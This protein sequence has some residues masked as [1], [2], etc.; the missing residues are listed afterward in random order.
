MAPLQYRLEKR[1]IAAVQDSHRHR[2]LVIDFAVLLECLL[3]T[4]L[5]HV[6]VAAAAVGY[7]VARGD[8]RGITVDGGD[9]SSEITQ[10]CVLIS[11]LIVCQSVAL[12]HADN[13]L[14]QRR[15]F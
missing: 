7:F 2:A 10:K 4:L 13:C 11:E 3:V 15:G 8:Q 5:D 12:V 9:G 1:V 6:D 14:Q